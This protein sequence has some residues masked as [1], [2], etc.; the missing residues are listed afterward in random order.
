MEKEKQG[1][2]KSGQF[3]KGNNFAKGHGGASKY[4]KEYAAKLIEYFS[5]PPTRVEYVKYY[6]SDGK[7]KRE[8][9]VVLGADY[10]TF[11]GFA[12]TIGVTSRTL[13]NWRANYAGFAEACER[14]EDIAHNI[15]IVNGLAGNYNGNFAKF[16]A[17]N[18]FDMAEKSEQKIT[19]DEGWNVKITVEGGEKNDADHQS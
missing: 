7:V 3:T 10:P 18:Q 1:R 9:P 19:G 11:A 12:T 17:S 5:K 2:N 13:E 15:L 4:K 8:E 6:D 16:I 14:A